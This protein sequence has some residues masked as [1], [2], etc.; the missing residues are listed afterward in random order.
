MIKALLIYSLAL[1]A[2]A[3]DYV[4]RTA[5]RRAAMLAAWPLSSTE[6]PSR[7]GRGGGATGRTV[8]D[9]PESARRIECAQGP[10][11]NAAARGAAAAARCH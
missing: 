2:F 4:F 11:S 5:R 9:E 7:D 6:R 10:G 3:G 1:L 8:L